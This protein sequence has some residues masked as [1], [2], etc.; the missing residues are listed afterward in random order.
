MNWLISSIQTAVWWGPKMVVSELHNLVWRRGSSDWG[1]QPKQMS[2]RWINQ[3]VIAFDSKK[4]SP[5]LF[6]SILPACIL[7]QSPQNPICVSASWARYAII[8]FI[9]YFS[10]MH[11][12]WCQIQVAFKTKD[13]RT[14]KLNLQ[15]DCWR[16]KRKTYWGARA[17]QGSWI[18]CHKLGKINTCIEAKSYIFVF[19]SLHEKKAIIYWH[20]IQG[21]QQTLGFIYT[22]S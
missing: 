4:R 3:E 18:D 16:K 10:H 5:G 8:Y 11:I 9:D 15:D 20:S 6:S 12:K 19:V 22:C 1:K 7:T 2:S 21:D 17:Q 14:K 13:V